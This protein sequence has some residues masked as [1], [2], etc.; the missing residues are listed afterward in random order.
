MKKISLIICF[1]LL[2]FGSA[3][4]QG[5]E[6][7]QD[8][9]FA[10][11]IRAAKSDNAAAAILEEASVSFLERNDFQKFVDFLSGVIKT[12]RSLSPWVAY[13]TGMARYRQMKYLEE[14][15]S[16]DEYFSKGN[17]YRSEIE[18]NLGK[19][20]K[21]FAADEP[22]RLYSLLHLWQ[23]HKDQ[24]DVFN[25]QALSDLMAAAKAYA[26]GQNADLI[27]LKTVADKLLAYE[28]RSRA[29]ELYK[30]YG[31]RII[32]SDLSE[33]ELQQLRAQNVV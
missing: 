6:S 17:E 7:A 20:V 4:G 1:F 33:D 21:Y 9:D 25:E 29:R 28:E 8:K 24:Q 30:I 11:L 31:D 15:Q 26:S 10:G 16:W 23:F 12:K 22:L 2:A 3:C 19:A 13:Y 32:S 5:P 27:P 14:T 18:Q